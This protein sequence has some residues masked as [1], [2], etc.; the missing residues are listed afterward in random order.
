VAY[1]STSLEWISLIHKREYYSGIAVVP[2]YRPDVLDVALL[3][4][5]LSSI[6]T[7]SWILCHWLICLELLWHG[8]GWV[9]W[10]WTFENYCGRHCGTP[11]RPLVWR[12][13]WHEWLCSYACDVLAE[14]RRRQLTNVH[15]WAASRRRVRRTVP[16]LGCSVLVHGPCVMLSTS[17]PSYR[18]VTDTPRLTERSLFTVINL[19]SPFRALTL[20]VN[21]KAVLSQRWPRDAPYIWVP[22]IFGTPWLR[23][24][25]LFPHFMVFCSDRPYECSYKIWSP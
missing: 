13:T 10:N 24:R 9:P 11:F 7:T 4:L 19:L 17:C 25:L 6:L 3:T 8:L 21:K 12:V 20:L 16:L 5:L 18:A 23:P 15:Q 2:F 1:I 14:L 22:W